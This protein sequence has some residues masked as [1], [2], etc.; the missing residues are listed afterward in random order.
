MSGSNKNGTNKNGGLEKGSSV[1]PKKEA[2]GSLKDMERKRRQVF[3]PV[4]DNPFTQSSLWPFV[5]P[6]IAGTIVDSLSAILSGLGSYNRT[7]QE[8]ARLDKGSK[9]TPPEPE[10][11]QH[12]TI[13]FNS[14]VE[15]LEKQASIHR[16]RLTTKKHKPGKQ[17]RYLKYVF[18][19]KYDITPA[20]LT[21]HFPVLAFTASSSTENKVKLVQLPRGSMAK[22]SEVLHMENTGIL[23]FE[24]HIKEAQF[25]FK[26]VDEHIKDVEVPWLDGLFDPD[27]GDFFSKPALS[28]LSTSAPILPKKNDQKAKKK[29]ATTLEP[30]KPTEDN[31]KQKPDS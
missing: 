24:A 1:P 28:F 5:E 3:K 11:K 30:P 25:L 19:T 16:H 8:A 6:E 14:T 2:T 26:Y 13:G 10:I 12:I 7:V 4:L 31:K 15:A 22:L 17:G 21:N 20:V 9:Q 18:V 23:G 29:Q 27:N